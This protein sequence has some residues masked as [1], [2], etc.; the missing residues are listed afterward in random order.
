MKEETQHALEPGFIIVG[1]AKSGTTSLHAL[2]GQ[3]PGIHASTPKETNFFSYDEVHARGWQWYE[4]CFAGLKDGQVAGEGSPT[5][6]DRTSYPRTAERMA[7]ALPNAKLIYIVRDPVERLASH[8]RMLTRDD[9]DTPSFKKALKSGKLRPFLAERSSYWFQISAFRDRY[10][11]SQI[12]VVFF[13]DFKQD[14]CREL[15]RCAAFV[16]VEAFAEISNPKRAYNSGEEMTGGRSEKQ[17]LQAIRKLPLVDAAKK[18]IPEPLKEMLWNL[19]LFTRKQET[20]VPWTP[21]LKKQVA[22]ELRED[23]AQFLKFYGKPA[24]YWKMDGP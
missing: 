7:A 10:P 17:A 16:G 22:D 20:D 13:E 6:S 19:P 12:L 11:D 18:L 15:N 14:P 21:E 4:S 8:W 1:S 5:Y 9:A 2:L 23:A 24:D 3:H